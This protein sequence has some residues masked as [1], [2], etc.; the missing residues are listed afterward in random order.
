MD[1]HALPGFL[2]K[3]PITSW[4][5]FLVISMGPARPSPWRRRLQTIL[6]CSHRPVSD[7]WK[8]FDSKTSA[9]VSVYQESREQTDPISCQQLKQQWEEEC[10]KKGRKEEE[11]RAGSRLP[12]SVLMSTLQGGG[13]RRFGSSSCGSPGDGRR[14]SCSSDPSM[15]PK[16]DVIK[17]LGS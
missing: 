8:R 14:F 13:Q 6:S 4:P 2:R 15:T 17:K 3:C 16:Y 1:L 11:N 10:G 9:S 7:F 5:P 12:P